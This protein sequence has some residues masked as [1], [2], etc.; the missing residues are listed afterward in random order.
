MT[1]SQ[2]PI[3]VL[4]VDDSAVI[5]GLMSQSL[6][7]VSEVSVVGRAINGEMAV[8]QAKELQPDV[9]VLDI[10]MPVMDGLTALPKILEAAPKCKVIM[11]STLTV[12]NAKVS[13]QALSLGA[14]DYLAKPEAKTGHEA[15]I[16]Y[17]ELTG[18][19]LALGGRGHVPIPP[20]SLTITS[21]PLPLLKQT[22]VAPRVTPLAPGGKLNPM[23]IHALAI[24]SSTGGPQALTTVMTGL[25]GS[26][27]NIPIFITQHMPA[28]FTTI[29]A[30]QLSGIS[31]RP[32]HEAKDGM[33]VQ[34]GSVYLAPGDFHMEPIR[35]GAAQIIIKL[36]QNPPENFCRP[37]ADPMLRALSGI[38]GSH[39]LT[40]V[41]T[42]M[43]SDGCE[44][45]KEVVNR[46]GSV[47]AQNEA[48]CVVYGMPRAVVEAGICKSVLPLSDIPAF[49]VT[50][51]DGRR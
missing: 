47:I 30:E 10:E 51:I 45:A 8:M 42:G 34:P 48:S 12:R 6:D 44:G 9:V 13:M 46:G 3:R 39:L 36:N 23:G 4:I 7:T 37:A 43:G 26:L 24:A 50:Q 16:F 25:K 40:V 31:G 22:T 38:Y 18:K 5:R 11:A 35:E 20:P 29:L 32:V 21:A 33:V 2:T 49:L 17:R 27:K 28:M 15:E 41:L 14:T 19:I 1:A